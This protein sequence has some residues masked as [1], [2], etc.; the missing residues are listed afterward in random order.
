M[1]LGIDFLHLMVITLKKTR[2]LEEPYDT[3]EE[4]MSSGR[5]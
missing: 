1:S 4:G 3:S 5:Q 2:C